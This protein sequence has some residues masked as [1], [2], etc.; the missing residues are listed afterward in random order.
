METKDEILRAL[1][2]SFREAGYNIV[3]SSETCDLNVKASF[4]FKETGIPVFGSQSDLNITISIFA[5]GMDTAMATVNTSGA[6]R[7]VTIY[8]IPV[9]RSAIGCA[10]ACLVGPKGTLKGLMNSVVNELTRSDLMENYRRY[11][12]NIDSQIAAVMNRR[13]TSVGKSASSEISSTKRGR[14][15]AN[16]KTVGVAVYP[17]AGKGGAEAS[18][19]EAVSGLFSNSISSGSGLR[20]V[21]SEIIAD[22][23]KQAGLEQACGAQS[24]QVDLAAQAKA[25][26]LVRGELLRI[27]GDYFLT[28][29]VIDLH[30]K[31]TVFADRIKTNRD[32][33]VD[34]TDD[35]AL[36]VRQKLEQVH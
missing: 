33:I 3:E 20:L 29:Q 17:F 10:G 34:E 22:L 15:R 5:P 16:G 32:K 23:A 28:T 31:E 11:R 18:L 12:D 35:L 19:A 36:K 6:R 21:G 2:E 8:G 4:L 9:G 27:Q 1:Q 25:D 24:C 30:T 13:G 7:P 14:S 26:F